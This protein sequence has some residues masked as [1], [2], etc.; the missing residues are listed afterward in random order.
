MLIAVTALGAIA[1][2][3][4]IAILLY[5]KKQI[6]DLALTG[7]QARRMELHFTFVYFGFAVCLGLFSAVAYTDS[8]AE[9]QAVLVAL[10][11]GYGAGAAAG[12]SVRPRISI[13]SIVIATVPMIF[14]TVHQ[15]PL[16]GP[17]LGFLLSSVLG[18]GRSCHLDPI[19]IGLDT[20][21]DDWCFRHVGTE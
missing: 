4:R 15:P 3:G 12:L 16:T 17:I 14:A 10:V 19:P 8:S 13:P 20:H 7:A 6:N 21:N 1:L 9:I 11:I 2:L 5:Y 18:R